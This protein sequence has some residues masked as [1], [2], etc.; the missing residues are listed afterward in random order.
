MEANKIL[1]ADVL[2]II[3]D[4]RNKDYGAYNLRKTYDRRLITAFGSM[5]VFIGLLL[6]G[7]VVAGSIHYQETKII[8]MG[9]T[10]LIDVPVDKIMEPP[11]PT[12][13]KPIPPKVEIIR[14]NT[15]VIV[16]DQLVEVTDMPPVVESLENTTIGNINQKGVKDDN[17]TAPPV[18]D[19]KRGILVAPKKEED[20]PFI[21]VDVQIESQY[22]GGAGAWMRYLN[23]T[24]RYPEEAQASGT[25]GTVTVQFI[26]DK[27]G[28]V[29]DVEAISGPATGGLRE[30]AVRVI[31]KSGRWE[32]AIQNGRKVKSYKKQPIIFRLND[33]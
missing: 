31:K 2:D 6:V 22:I 15:P 11:P 14:Y 25:Q 1:N 12:L 24:F 27:E 29:S 32:P 18:T 17:I 19:E 8:E 5:I 7:Y 9:D 20:E 4:G 16:K 33:E 3:F 26:V 13:P 23:K 30:E 28:N 21:F 10:H